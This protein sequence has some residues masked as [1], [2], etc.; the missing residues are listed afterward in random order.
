MR[1]LKIFLAGI[2][3]LSF[4]FLTSS[5]FCADE[6][7]ILSDSEK[8]V[9][10]RILVHWETW[11]PAKKADG[12]APMISFEELYAGLTSEEKNFLDSV[13]KVD[14]K[15]SFDFQGGFLGAEVSASFRRIENQ[16]ITKDGKE[17]VLDPQYLPEEVYAAYEKMMTAMEKDLG[18]RLLVESGFRSHAYQ[19]Y[20]F[21]F[22]TPKHH[23]SLKETGRWVA[24]P[25]YSEHGA[26]DRQA[27]DFINQEGINGEDNPEEF[28]SLPEYGWLMD[29]AGEFGFE[30]SYPRAKQGITFEPWHWCC[31][32]CI[33]PKINP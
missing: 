26:P 32:H 15:K 20:T 28:E 29:H 2:L 9:L 8:A 18:K 33:I 3:I 12:T 21:L 16:V 6:W 4:S 22:Y 19:L 27:I 30:L 11:V 10:D 7:D 5:G 25:G 24:L 1:Y 23:Y 14:P 17:Q 31:S 13:R